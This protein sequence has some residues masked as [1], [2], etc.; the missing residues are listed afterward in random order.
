ME[1]LIIIEK[2]KYGYGAYAP[3]FPGVGVV[4]ETRFEV[5]K[6]VKEAIELHIDDLKTHKRRIPKPR[7]QAVSILV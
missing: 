7:N 1:Y 5:L 3:D 4:A 2:S 6:L